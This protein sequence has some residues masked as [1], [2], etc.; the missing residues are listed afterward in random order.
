[1]VDRARQVVEEP[2]HRR[3]VGRVEGGGGVRVE[4]VRGPLEALGV[5]AGH[6]DL[7]ALAAGAA[8]RL[9]ADPGA[10]AD[11]DDGLAEQF[12]LVADRDAAGCG[13]HASSGGVTV[14][15]TEVAARRGELAPGNPPVRSPGRRPVTTR[16][17]AAPRARRLTEPDPRRHR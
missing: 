10:A 12:G 1:M 15:G 4:V 3:G 2:L 11:H 6:D 7:G 17:R 5:A 9:E 13:A 14:W 8:G 16:A